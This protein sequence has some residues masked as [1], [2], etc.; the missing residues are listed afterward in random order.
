MTVA[1]TVAITA[2]PK[3]EPSVF[4]IINTDTCF[5]KLFLS[6]LY[7]RHSLTED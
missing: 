1:P 7:K 5:W 4:N 6:S 3:L 2:D